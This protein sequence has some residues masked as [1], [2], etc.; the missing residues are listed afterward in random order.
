MA[1]RARGWLALCA[2]VFV[3]LLSSA[4][5]A[6]EEEPPP[7][8]EEASGIKTPPKKKAKPLLWLP[9]AVFYVPAQVLDLA[10]T[11]VRWGLVTY[12]QYALKTRALDVFFNKQRTFGVVP[13]LFVETG[14]GF[15]G[16]VRV[17]HRD[18]AGNGE[19]LF[20]RASYGGLYLQRY[21]VRLGSGGLLGKR[22]R[23]DLRGAYRIVPRAPFFGIGN[24][25]I[26]D[27]LDPA[28]ADATNSDFAAQ[29]RYRRDEAQWGTGLEVSVVNKL[30]FQ[31][32]HLWTWRQFSPAIDTPGG[33]QTQLRY[34]PSSLTTFLEGQIG[35]YT[36]AAF[37][38][39]TLHVTAP[40]LSSAAPSAGWLLRLY[41]GYGFGV[42]HDPSNYWRYGADLQRFINLWGGNR[43]LHLRLAADVVEA[44]M[45]QIPFVDLPSLGGP[46]YLR[47]YT[48]DRFRDRI[49]GLGSVEY[50]W[51][52]VRYAS[53]YIFADVGRVWNRA[54]LPFNNM[55][56]GYGGGI[57]VHTRRAFVMRLQL[58]SSIDGGLFFQF[59]LNPTHELRHNV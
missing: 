20:V 49:S 57:Q 8:P 34:D 40:H 25:D 29:T 4:A 31:L 59:N 14:F 10:V 13:I 22:V 41:G 58:A 38:Y 24:N 39:N 6:T 30:V 47:G 7:P 55:R 51:P 45:D 52:L 3:S 15:N 33:R 37:E 5:F 19:N 18:L 46:T 9:R 54:P 17:I 56:F 28:L 43:T 26:S 53:P 16:G 23:L 42:V 12:E 11:P 32:G 44:P 50:I 48:R 1:D 2:F 21:E 35:A 36:E 27:E